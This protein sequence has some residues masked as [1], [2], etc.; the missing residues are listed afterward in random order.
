MD[1]TITYE[2]LQEFYPG[3]MVTIEDGTVFIFDPET[4]DNEEE[5]FE[6]LK[7][8]IQ[9]EEKIPEDETIDI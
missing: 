4:G 9:D 6:A 1:D 3:K 8:R 7:K 5:S 2:Q